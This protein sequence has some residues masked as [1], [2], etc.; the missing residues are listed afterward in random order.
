MLNGEKRPSS[1]VTW[2]LAVLV[3]ILAAAAAW[4]LADATISRYACLS[5]AGGESDVAAQ[6]AS[7]L[8]VFVAPATIAWRLRRAT[9]GT[10]FLP[11]ASSL[12]LSLILVYTV[13][14]VW[15]SDH[16]CYT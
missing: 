3:P 11:V 10:D 9:R 6:A 8:L 12:L 16:N 7:G 2:G 13:T 4:L 1:L 5:G 15:W 14:G